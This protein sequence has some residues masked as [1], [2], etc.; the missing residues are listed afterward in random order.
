MGP[1]GSTG[2]VWQIS[3]GQGYPQL[4]GLPASIPAP[5]PDNGSA[6]FEET[7]AYRSALVYLGGLG[8]LEK[9]TRDD[10]DA[11][12]RLNAAAEEEL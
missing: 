6:G 4:R 5:V 10:D 3:E 2:T 11:A 1:A 7:P 9:E 8:Q 12:A